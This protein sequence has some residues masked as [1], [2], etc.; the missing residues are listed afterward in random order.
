MPSLGLSLCYPPHLELK[1]RSIRL[2]FISKIQPSKS[3]IVLL[4]VIESIAQAVYNDR[5]QESN[6]RLGPR[7]LSPTFLVSVALLTTSPG[8][9]LAHNTAW[10]HII[11]RSIQPSKSR[12]TITLVEED[13]PTSFL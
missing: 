6:K 3:Y 12:P 7:Y 8:T 1:W 13:W 11:Q 4:I 2:G 10:Q 9:L 5:D